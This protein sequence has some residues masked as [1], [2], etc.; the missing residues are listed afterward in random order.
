MNSTGRITPALR[1]LW[2]RSYDR[3]QTC[4]LSLP[5]NEFALAG[6]ATDGTPLYVGACC[7][8]LVHELATPV[9]W[10]WERDKRCDPQ[11]RLW[12]YMDFAKFIALLDHRALHF[13]RADHLGDP[14]DGASG[15]ADQRPRWDAH[16]L[17]F[18]RHAVRTTPDHPSPPSEADVEN[19]AQRLLREMSEGWA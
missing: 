9:Y 16:Y 3:C 6:Y 8:E 19:Q 15:S 1:H 5:Q 18:F 10:Y 2:N 4:S 14:F 17:D 11:M 12:R 7:R 13:A